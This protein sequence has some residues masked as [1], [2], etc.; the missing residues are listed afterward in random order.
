MV[1]R[2][3]Y[4]RGENFFFSLLALSCVSRVLGHKPQ[5]TPSIRPVLRD[6]SGVKLS[7]ATTSAVDRILMTS[8]GLTV[9]PK[10][11]FFE[12]ENLNFAKKLLS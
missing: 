10:L 5:Q 8:Y 4:E 7:L 6:I 11:I 12:D 3:T 9:C 2:A 1:Q